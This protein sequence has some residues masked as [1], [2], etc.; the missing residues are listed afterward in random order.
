MCRALRRSSS[1]TAQ[2]RGL[3]MTVATACPIPPIGRILIETG[4][5]PESEM[6]LVR[7]KGWLRA[8]GLGEGE[9]G[10]EL[11]RRNRSFVFFPAGRGFRL[12]AWPGRGGWRCA[13]AAPL[14]RRRSG[15][16][17]SMVCRSGSRRT[18]RG[19]SGRSKPVP[20]PDDCAGHRR[21]DCRTGPRRPLFRRR[22]RG[23]SARRGDSACGRFRRADAGR[24]SSMKGEV[25]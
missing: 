22:R 4:E 13:D 17:V 15:P 5:I 25:P 18:C 21:G 16:V 11:M 6:S 23:G 7:L 24:R 12:R 20:P 8:A 1:P 3:L 9:R 2:G 14:D 10:L 19:Q